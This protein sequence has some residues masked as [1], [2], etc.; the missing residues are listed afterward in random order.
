MQVC[1]E[2]LDDSNHSTIC[3]MKGPVCMED[4]LTLL[5]SEQDARRLR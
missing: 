5:E 1:I 2:F 3:S 4:I